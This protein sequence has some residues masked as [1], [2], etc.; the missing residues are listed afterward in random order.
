HVSKPTA[1]SLK[2]I[3]IPELCGSCHR[4]IAGRQDGKIAT[5]RPLMHSGG[6]TCT[7]CHD[8]HR[9]WAK[10]GGISRERKNI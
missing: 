5:V 7:R 6:V 8:P 1:S 10:L 2:I 9:P 3:G 4:Q